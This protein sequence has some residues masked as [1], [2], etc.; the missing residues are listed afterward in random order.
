MVDLFHHS[1]WSNSRGTEGSLDSIA[2]VIEAPK[3]GSR[4]HVEKDSRKIKAELGWRSCEEIR[5]LCLRQLNRAWRGTCETLF[6]DRWGLG[7]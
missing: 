2:L 5:N 7:S 1:G 3:A 6:K 4:L